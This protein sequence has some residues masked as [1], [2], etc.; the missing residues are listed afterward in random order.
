MRRTLLY[1]QNT[2]LFN[3][4]TSKV[5]LTKRPKLSFLNNFYLCQ[6]LHK[7]KFATR[8]LKYWLNAKTKTKSAF[9]NALISNVFNSEQQFYA[10]NEIEGIRSAL[11]KNHSSIKI[12]DFGAGSTIN[13]SNERKISDVITHSAKT[14]KLGQMMFRLINQFKPQNMLEL[15]T[16]LGVSACYQIGANRSAE[17]TTLEGCPETAEIAKKVLSSFKA[18]HV[19]IKIGDFAATLPEVLASYNQLDYV[20]FDG[21]HQK[22]PTIEYFNKCLKKVHENTIFIF[23][24]IHWSKDM[25]EA[26]ELIKSH[27]SV[28]V[29]IDKFWVGLVFFK[30]NQPVSHFTIR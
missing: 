7:F 24:D 11:K 12:T 6:M 20:F 10:F 27:P 5:D 9:V 30:K 1:V 4:V 3:V 16:S 28:T 23:D 22:K 13:K 17:F 21:N 18:E 2:S 19:K 14:P 29:T 8:Y 15:G 25:E 26:W